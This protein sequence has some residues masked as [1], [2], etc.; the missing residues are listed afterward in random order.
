MIVDPAMPVADIATRHPLA[1]RVFSRHGLD[2]CCGGHE[3]LAETCVEKDLDLDQLMA[4]L[5]AELGASEDSERRW[6]QASTPELI[7]HIISFYHE[8][9]R[10]EL[11]RLE[12]MAKKVQR[13]HGDKDPAMFDGMLATFLAI[14]ADISQHLDVEE[15]TLFPAF[16]A[17]SNGGETMQSIEAEHVELGVLLRDL[18]TLTKDYVVPEEACNTWRGQWFGLEELEG[19]MHRHIHLENHV[20]HPRMLKA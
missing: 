5:E 1:T 17:G 11:P 7:A 8:P 19:A 3:P 14:Q 4:E 16:L 6:D 13:V 15:Q 20:L 18:R 9:L 10:E 2:F 12:L